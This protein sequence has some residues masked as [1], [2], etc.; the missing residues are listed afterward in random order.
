MTINKSYVFLF[1]K[2]CLKEQGFDQKYE[3]KNAKFDDNILLY[4]TVYPL[5]LANKLRFHIDENPKT[6]LIIYIITDLLIEDEEKGLFP[7]LDNSITDVSRFIETCVEEMLS[8]YDDEDEKLDLEISVYCL[9]V[10]TPYVH[11]NIPNNLYR[12]LEDEREQLKQTFSDDFKGKGVKKLDI[13]SYYVKYDKDREKVAT[14]ELLN[15]KNNIMLKKEKGVNVIDSS[16]FIA[17]NKVIEK[18]KLVL[19]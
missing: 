7:Y 16:T 3:D 11:G 19:N 15:L 1:N 14:N 18:H 9:A 8:S 4:S 10:E 17:N 2:E 13:T 5:K 12:S 6:A